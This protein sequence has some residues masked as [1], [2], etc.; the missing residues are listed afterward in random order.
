MIVVMVKMVLVVVDGADACGRETR[1]D[2]DEMC[3][4]DEMCKKA[5]LQTVVVVVEKSHLLIL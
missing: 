1:V 4:D 3:V 5:A 2:V